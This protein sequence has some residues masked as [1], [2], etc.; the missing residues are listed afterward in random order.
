MHPAA[1]IKSVCQER[2]INSL[3]TNKQKNAQQTFKFLIKI[4]KTQ[5]VEQMSNWFWYQHVR[6][7]KVKKLR[8]QQRTP[9]FQILSL[10]TNK[11]KQV[12]QVQVQFDFWESDTT[13]RVVLVRLDSVASDEGGLA[14]GVDHQQETV[15]QPEGDCGEQHR[16]C[17]N[18]GIV[19][20][21]K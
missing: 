2:K 18:G 5:L 17:G 15:Q 13:Y 20:D 14:G 7:V 16:P 9:I 6:A 4:K 10:E 8:Q 11:N 1:N 12:R 19:N 3:K 21:G